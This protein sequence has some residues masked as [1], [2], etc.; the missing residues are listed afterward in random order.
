MGEARCNNNH[1]GND[2]GEGCINGN[3]CND[4]TL[5]SGVWNSRYTTDRS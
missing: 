3:D 1:N 4:D 5:Y 2:N